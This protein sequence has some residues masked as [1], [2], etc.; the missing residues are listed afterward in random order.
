M[1]VVDV[2]EMVATFLNIVA[3]DVKNRVIQRE[4][5]RSGSIADSRILRDAISR[6]NGLKVPKG[7]Y[8]LI[9]TSMAS[10]SKLPKHSWTKEE[11]AGPSMMRGPTCNRF[12]WNDEQKCIVAEKEV[13]DNW[14]K[15]H[16]VAKGLLNKSFPHYDELSYMF[17]KD[18][19]TGVRAETFADVGSN[20]PTGYEAFVADAT[21]DGLP[22]NVQSR[23]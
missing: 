22:A 18:R 15:S 20:D 19:A 7:Y 12:R 16:P 8:Y 5:M 11:E 6:P 1:E 23:M 14:V 13:F 9:D 10:I 2:K 17:G 3:H 21:S 4:F